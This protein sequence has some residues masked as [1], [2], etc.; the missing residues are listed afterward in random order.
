MPQVKQYALVPYSCEQMY[1]LVNDYE[2]YPEFVPG[3]IDA[4]AVKNFQKNENELKACLIISKA[5]IQQQFT[6]HNKMRP[7]HFIQMHLLEG[8]FKF[9]NGEWH[10]VALDENS[11]K[12]QLDLHFEFINPLMSFAFGKIFTHLTTHMIDAFKKRAKEIY[13]G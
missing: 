3:C 11:C 8:P 6:T 12:I 4:H 5:G 10:F 7:P 13:N 2:R 9:L 1:A